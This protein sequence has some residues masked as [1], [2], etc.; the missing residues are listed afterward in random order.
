MF[1][2]LYEETKQW[3]SDEIP[4]AAITLIIYSLRVDA[5]VGNAHFFMDLDIPELS[6]QNRKEKLYAGRVL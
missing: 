5:I 3:L 2:R 1:P 4:E 6:R